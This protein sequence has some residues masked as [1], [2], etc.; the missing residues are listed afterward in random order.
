[1]VDAPRDLRGLHD[2]VVIAAF[3][4]WNDAGDAATGAVEHLA[5]AYGAE[6]A[7]ALDP[8][9]F[10]DYQVNRPHVRGR[11]GDRELIWPTTEIK[12]SELPD[13]RDLVLVQGLEPNISWR[14]LS[15]RIMSAL[16]TAKPQPI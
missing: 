15:A 10:Y 3:G 7:Y 9:D 14:Q 6:L 2:P 13:G 8:D 16:T 1:M 12:V 4:G 11:N 5:A